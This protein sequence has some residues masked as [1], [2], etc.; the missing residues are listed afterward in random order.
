MM[1]SAFN[2]PPFL[3]NTVKFFN[4]VE[5]VSKVLKA[6]DVKSPMNP[7][8]K[9][10]CNDSRLGFLAANSRTVDAVKSDKCDSS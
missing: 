8:S 6:S 9:D 5:S 10:K 7:L 4:E 3:E 2:F 1:H